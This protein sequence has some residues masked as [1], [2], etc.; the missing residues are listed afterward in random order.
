MNFIK[1]CTEVQGT[2]DSSDK[3]MFRMRRKM[4]KKHILICSDVIEYQ[5]QIGS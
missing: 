3:D 5:K 4:R 2:Y 1:K